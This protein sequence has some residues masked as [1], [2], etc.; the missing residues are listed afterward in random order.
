MR[1]Q[2][3][4]ADTIDAA[5]ADHLD[6]TAAGDRGRHRRSDRTA[7]RHRPTRTSRDR[8]RTRGRNPS[9]VASPVLRPPRR[10]QRHRLPRTPRPARPS[11]RH[12]RSPSRS[13]CRRR[14]RHRSLRRRRL[15]IRLPKR[16]AVAAE[17]HRGPHTAVRAHT[18]VMSC[19]ATV[20]VTFDSGAVDGELLARRAGPPTASTGT[21]LEQI[22]AD[23]RVSELIASPGCSG[24]VSADT[25][26]LV[27]ALVRAWHVTDGVFDPTLLGTFVELGTAASRERADVTTSLAPGNGPRGRPAEILV[28]PPTGGDAAPRHHARCRRAGQGPR[29]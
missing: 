6:H 20:V 21:A 3:N 25:F 23:E 1:S 7:D 8:R 2:G 27:E 11:R 15:R 18:H 19:D 26:R 9:A 4:N 12:N 13:T 17:T 5:G 14:H 16:R 28:E 24:Q 29:C 22:P 10:S